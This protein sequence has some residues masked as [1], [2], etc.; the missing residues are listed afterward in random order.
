[1][2]KVTGAFEVTCLDLSFHRCG[3][4]GSSLQGTNLWCKCHISVEMCKGHF[5]ACVTDVFL[6]IL[7]PVP[8]SDSRR[9]FFSFMNEKF[10]AS[11]GT[12]FC[13][14]WF[15]WVCRLYIG[16]WWPPEAVEVIERFDSPPRGWLGRGASQWLSDKSVCN[17][18]NAGS[19]PRSGR[20]P[21]GGHGNPLQYSCLG[22]PMDRGAW[23]A[24]VQGVAKSQTQLKR[25]S[26]HTRGWDTALVASF[27]P[28]MQSLICK[29]KPWLSRLFF[30]GP[31]TGTL[32]SFCTSCPPTQQNAHETATMVLILFIFQ[33]ELFGLLI[34]SVFQRGL[35]GLSQFD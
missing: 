32:S 1:M 12:G 4:E 9:E 28:Q 2:C 6:L 21:G 13:C 35:F 25:L 14:V 30:P 17:A 23:W 18:G 27:L 31:S 7:F 15:E 8:G 19:I 24:A 3:E 33:R 22:N 10:A 5:D 16:S 29:T 34:L 11:V 26:M 20:C